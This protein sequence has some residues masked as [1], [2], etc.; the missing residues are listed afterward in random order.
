MENARCIYIFPFFLRGFSDILP[1][2]LLNFLPLFLQ[3]KHRQSADLVFRRK[4]P[5]FFRLR[6]I[7][8][9]FEEILATQNVTYIQSTF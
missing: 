5:R 7:F 3:K 4:K 1:L 2:R 9:K 8:C 6:V